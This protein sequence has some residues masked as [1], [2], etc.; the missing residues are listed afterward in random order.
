MSKVLGGFDLNGALMKNRGAQC[1]KSY[2]ST[3]TTIT[4]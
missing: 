1:R 2:S 4:K 3:T